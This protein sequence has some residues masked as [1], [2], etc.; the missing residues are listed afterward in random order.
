MLDIRTV[1]RMYEDDEDNISQES[2]LNK[3][4]YNKYR[5]YIPKGLEGRQTQPIIYPKEYIEQKKQ[6]EKSRDLVRAYIESRDKTPQVESTNKFS[7]EQRAQ[8]M[9][10]QYTP[11]LTDIRRKDRE[12]LNQP[13]KRVQPVSSYLSSSASPSNN[14]PYAAAHQDQKMHQNIEQK[15]QDAAQ[16]KWEDAKK[17]SELD[18]IGFQSGNRFINYST[19]PQRADYGTGIKEGMDKPNLFHSEVYGLM[20]YLDPE[21][22]E[23][24]K[25]SKYNF[26]RMNE[27]EKNIYYYLNG[28]FGAEAA[29]N[30]IKSINRELNE[31]NIEAVEESA[32]EL[33]KE[34]PVFSSVLDAAIAPVTA[35]AY[36]AMLAEQATNAISGKYEPMDPNDKYLG[37]AAILESLRSGVAENEGIKKV[38]PN[39]T[40][41]EFL[42]GTG[43]SIGENIARLPFGVYGLAAAAGSAG[44]SG[45]RDAA[46]RGGTAG[47]AVASGAVNAAAEAFFEKFSLDGLER[48]KV[49]PGRGIKE[50][51]KNVGKQ[52]ITEGSE[53]TATEIVNT[54]SDAV[55]MK[56][57]SQYNQ[58]YQTYKEAGADDETAKREAFMGLLKNVGLAGLGGAIS[59]GIMG[60]GSQALG[61]AGLSYYGSKIDQDYR[62][63]AD[64]IDTDSAHYVRPE[65]AREAQELQRA[66]QE[67][68][69]LQRQGRYVP[70]RDKA[71]YDIRMNQFMDNLQTRSQGPVRPQNTVV[72]ADDKTTVEPELIGTEPVNHQLTEKDVMPGSVFKTS[73]SVPQSVQSQTTEE[74]KQSGDYKGAYGKYGGEALLDTYDGTVE[75]SVYNKA[76]GRAYDAG[77]HNMDLDM[78]EHSAIMSVLTDKQIEAAYRAGIQDYNADNKVI[79]QYTQGEARDGGL[80]SVSELAGQDQRKVADYIGKKTGLKINLIDSMEDGATAS[81]KS[82]E[83]T[84]DVGSKDFNGAMSHE[85]T[86]FIKE[87][88]PKAY[89][90]YQSVVVEAEMKASGRSWE[91]LIESYGR[92]YS[93]AGQELTR[94]EVIE[95]IVADATQKFFNDSEFVDAVIKKDKKLAQRI[96]DFLTDVVDSIKNLIQTGS[97]RAAAKNLEENAQL[98]EEARDIWMYGL[99]KA[100]ES[101][102]SGRSRQGD[103][104]KYQLNQFG[105]EEYTQKEK[106]NLKSDRIMFAN[107][108]ADIEKFTDQADHSKLTMLYMGNIGDDLGNEIFSKVGIDLK[109]YSIVLRSD[110]VFKIFKDHGTDMEYQRGQIPITVKELMEIPNIIANADQIEK[111][112]STDHGKPAIQ[113]IKNINGKNVVVEYVSDKRRMLYTQTM[114]INKKNPPTTEDVLAP[115]LTSQTVSGTDLKGDENIPPTPYTIQQG[116]TKSNSDKT[117]FQLDGVDEAENDITAVLEENESLKKANENLI[118]QM[119]LLKNSGIKAEDVKAIARKVRKKYQSNYDQEALERRLTRLFKYIHAAESLNGSDVTQAVYGIAKG[120]LKQSAAVDREMMENYRDLRK[121]IRETK[122]SISEADRADLAADGGYAEFKKRYRGRI[123]FADDGISVDSFYEELMEMH[124]ELF[125]ADVTHPADRLRRIGDVVDATEIQTVNPYHAEMNKVVPVVAQEIL[126]EYTDLSL[127]AATAPER[128]RH[129]LN[130]LQGEYK[131]ML[132]TY[133]ND[134]REEFLDNQSRVKRALIDEQTSLTKRYNEAANNLETALKD[135]NKEREKDFRA[136]VKFYKERIEEVRSNLNKVDLITKPK[137]YIASMEKSRERKL[138]TQRKRQI[139]RDVMTIQKW[140][141]RPEKEKHIPDE[142]KRIVLDFLH[143]IDYSSAHMNQRGEPTART[144]SW[145]EL[146]Q[147][148]EAVKDTSEWSENGETVYCDCDPDIVN[149]LQELKKKVYDINKLEELSAYEMEELQK[150]VSTLKKTIMEVNELKANRRAENVNKLSEEIVKDLTALKGKKE[151]AGPVSG[152][153]DKILNYENL[154]PYTMFW[155]MGKG[156]ESVYDTFREAL[157]KKTRMLKTAEDCV[158][159]AKRELGI[160]SKELRAW[161]GKQAQ[162]RVF[163]MSG[164]TITLTPAQIMALYEENKRGQA[165]GHIYGFGI[166]HAPII[167]HHKG[168]PSTIKRQYKPIRV[169]PEDIYMLTETLSDKQKKF[170]DVLQQFLSNDAAVWGNEASVEMYGYKKFN[171]RDYFPITTNGNYIQHK[172][173]DLSNRNTTIRNLGMTKNTVR[174][175][176]NAV[177]IE[178]IFDVFSRHVDQMSSYS[179]LLAPLSD[180]NKIYNFRNGE[181]NT[182]VMQE[183]EHAMGK[184]ALG[185]LEHLIQDINSDFKGDKAPWESMLSGVK[186]S[187]VAG[188]L[189][190]AIQQPTTYIRAMAELSPARLAQGVTAL[191]RRDRWQLI[192]K[193]AP[194]AQWKDWGFYQMNTSRSMKDIMFDTDSLA[195]KITNKSMVMA[196]M[197]DKIAWCQIWQACEREV[198]AKHKTLETGTEE[199]YQ[200]VGRRFSEVI[201]HTQ[202]ADSVLHRSQ[203]MRRQDMG[204]KIATSFMGE[205]ISTY[206]MLYRAMTDLKRNHNVKGANRVLA[207]IVLTSALSAAAR[208]LPVAMRDE[209]RD[210]TYGEKWK[211]TFVSSFLDNI[212]PLGL[213]PIAKDAY[214]A[215]KGETPTRT[216]VQGFQDIAYAVSKIQKLIEGENTYT[217]QYTAVYTAK[218]LSKLTGSPINNILREIEGIINTVTQYGVK[219]PQDDYNVLKQKYTMENKANLKLYARLMIESHRMGNRDLEEQIKRELN[220]AGIDNDTITKKIGSLIKAELVSKD[221]VDPR[222][223]AA[224]QARIAFDTEAYK[225]A[226]EQLKQEGYAE[227]MISSAVDTRTKELTGK[228]E[229]DWEAEAETQA[230]TLYDDILDND[231][232]QEKDEG[233]ITYKSTYSST[234]IIRSVEAIK[235][236]DINSLKAFNTVAE[237]YYETKKKNG[238]KKR[239]AIGDLRS[240]ITRK[241]KKEWIAA[242]N[243]GNTAAYEAIQNRLKQLKMEGSYLYSGKDWTD[244]RKDAKEKKKED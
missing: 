132:Q 99:E 122:L 96:I 71:E 56:E 133:K 134:L 3:T 2:T 10:Q 130:R 87:Q 17:Q 179:A 127:D 141:F 105:F 148:F 239:E 112:G 192:C 43:M 117:R 33:G 161:S 198:A 231:A 151:Y 27:D 78:A 138:K 222:I 104:N 123:R 174:N 157:D 165:R 7:E 77:Y 65:D 62:E 89:E 214:N 18:K 25:A 68:A 158:D 113:F 83:I 97:T 149:R 135:K 163:Q 79:P 150:V 47:Q 70:N 8:R 19:I 39:Q 178:D 129:E 238:V 205:P 61:N 242:Y 228:E 115:P 110:N 21:K 34:H 73:E 90:A 142:M 208:A 230:D 223:D 225:A 28:R 143:S 46:E 48:F 103:T 54:L 188:S 82:G 176:N 235:E 4:Q 189:S 226:V 15:T 199:Y 80:G 40:A 218:M 162:A 229:V 120:I 182:S 128:V 232:D 106:E 217:P 206:N 212:N 66:A 211:D 38:I 81:Y 125:E 183:I 32:K 200:A 44:L 155:Q 131:V 236:G 57:L 187:A 213:I 5:K 126:K 154:T 108:V 88:V 63:Y 72:S 13:S 166:T 216:D 153:A 69:K 202:V 14:I 197:G 243:S 119:E 171:A 164:G 67:Y 58:A 26:T 220:E 23:V 173:G 1:K 22:R 159:K 74:T 111:A 102:K 59:G 9:T 118:Q 175:A 209:D 177:V 227:K 184:G 41:R 193:Y 29:G 168:K 144:K 100:G 86:H 241:Y 45:T 95:E 137:Q 12:G 107:S 35:G 156:M 201:D 181:E 190:V 16:K 109:G 234:D 121:K 170:A 152:V 6:W 139:T 101:Y 244:W 36:P 64:S 169:T 191:P 219:G 207:A 114:W 167:E 240:I 186:A 30:Y 221:Y 185:Y 93:E 49:S 194:I 75:V 92:R 76:F 11:E 124:P 20:D 52:A 195:N 51:L 203:V 53:E 136:E 233:T 146:Q 55:I 42:V 160:S 91:D 31:R 215:I 196:E 24:S 224:A 50:F 147:F 145:D 37:Q 180:Y 60:G 140:L 172:E 98:Y 204:V 85:L 84:I 237:D 116:E 210:K 94:Q